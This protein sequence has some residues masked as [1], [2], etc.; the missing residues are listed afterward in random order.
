MRCLAVAP[1]SLGGMV[2]R[3]RAGP[4][5]DAALALL[6]T[7]PGPV[8]RLHPAMTADALQGGLDLTRTLQEGRPV[9]SPGALSRSGTFVLA[10]AERCPPEM[11][12]LLAQALDAG[13]DGPLVLLDEGA[14]E[15]ETPPALLAERLAFQVDLTGLALAD[16][17]PAGTGVEIPFQSRAPSSPGARSD[18]PVESGPVPAG[19][20]ATRLT[21]LAASFGIDSLRAPLFALAAARALAGGSPVTERHME[22]AALLTYPSRAT[23]LP[24]PPAEDPAPPDPSP[25][26]PEPSETQR[27]E[28]LPQDMLVEAIRATI[29]QGLLEQI[30][31]GASRTAKGSGAG[32]RR[33]GN[34]RGRPLP[35]RPGRPGNGQR[36]DL[37]ATLRRAAPWQKLRGATDRPI[38]WPSDLCLKRYEDRSDRLLIFA[39]DASGSAA[40]A[41]LAEAKG[42]V[43]LLLGEAYSR[44]DHVALIAFRGST[45]DLLLPPTRSLV[46][47]KRRLSA[48][49][50][51][52][53]TP[54]ATALQTAG[55][56]AVT[57]QAHGLSPTLALFTDGRANVALDGQGDRPRAQA[58]AHRL[59]RWLREMALPGIVLDAGRRPHPP[60]AELAATLGARYVPLPRAD[61]Q[62]LGATIRDGLG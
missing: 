52:G 12:A 35:S 46:Q 56:L 42:A 16:A 55:E 23:R 38:I 51:G 59:A 50:G 61:A 27:P 2:L 17:V 22:L 13:L 18:I 21:A 8:V 54:L 36:V 47:A 14:E 1:S 34:R 7:Q 41:R 10:M 29:P 11:A 44:R 40:L 53:G 58:D 5:R 3:A 32:Q 19:T 57:A 20:E 28:D 62:A 48:L 37:T 33:K 30:A 26:T 60:L 4:V 15:G 45:A 24:E 49:P 31:Q 25:D 9:Q 6:D 43:E 39:V